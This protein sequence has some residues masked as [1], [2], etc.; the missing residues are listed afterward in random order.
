MVLTFCSLAG[1][2]RCGYD[3]LVADLAPSV[4]QSLV[5]DARPQPPTVT[6]L[7]YNVVCLATDTV[8]GEYRYASVVINYNCSGLNCHE[9]GTF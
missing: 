2:Q 6:V 8:W 5:T 4:A 1:A 7:D 9:P 3:A